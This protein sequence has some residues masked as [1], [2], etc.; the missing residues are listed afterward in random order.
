MALDR[1]NAVEH[2]GTDLGGGTGDNASKGPNGKPQDDEAVPT[3]QEMP[4][5]TVPLN[6]IIAGVV[7][8]AYQDLQNVT[9]M[10]QSKPD[11]E[12]KRV[13][14]TYA[15]SQ[16]QQFIKLLAL[17]RWAKDAGDMKRSMSVHFALDE[18]NTALLSATH[19]LH[20]L[21]REMESLSQPSLDISTAVEVLTTGKFALPRI[22]RR[23]YV[24][25]QP[26]TPKEV[27]ETVRRVEGE[28]RVRL[29][30]DEVVPSVMR[31]NMKID[32][33]CVTFT[34]PNEFSVVLTLDGVGKDAKW[35]VVDIKILVSSVGVGYESVHKG[36]T[37][38]QLHGLK[39]T[40]QNRL[41]GKK[42]G[43]VAVL[44][45]DETKNEPKHYPL[46]ALYDCL[47][48]F[49]LRVQLEVLR[50]QAEHL[51]RTRWKDQLKVEFSGTAGVLRVEFWG[52]GSAGVGPAARPS[53]QT[54]ILEFSIQSEY[55]RSD[56]DWRKVGEEDGGEGE[57]GIDR[58]VSASL[59]YGN[60]G[61]VRRWM[62]GRVLRRGV[63]GEWEEEGVGEG[64]GRVGLDVTGSNLDLEHHL[65]RIVETLAHTLILSIQ[66]TF[67]STA[68]PTSHPTTLKRKRTTSTPTSG[69][70]RFHAD[71]ITVV[72]GLPIPQSSREEGEGGERDTPTP[73][74]SLLVS[75]IP[76]RQ[77]R[78]GISVRTGRVWIREESSSSLSS[79]DESLSRCLAVEGWVNDGR[80]SGVGGVGLGMLSAK[81]GLELEERC[82]EGVRWV[83]GEMM[84]DRVEGMAGEVGLVCLR[85]G[86]VG[87]EEMKKV[88]D[89][90]P[91]HRVFL[92]FRG[93]VDTFIVV[94]VSVCEG[95]GADGGREGRVRWR[96]WVVT[97]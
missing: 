94:G 95:G 56:V 31:R 67:L 97:T 43:N 11:H 82:V 33:G 88:S 77:I 16:R 91:E 65:L 15:L 7:T 20:S 59:T 53:T 52:A 4:E 19:A 40:A 42:K 9:K 44:A 2:P 62:E 10:A 79:N 21:K 6:H 12:K 74:P 37:D 86:V 78:I 73:A 66:S 30:V 22:L 8:T 96:V 63:K 54:R 55:P 48:P 46:V 25:D 72:P 1:G 34:V 47:H 14:M 57:G 27:E 45:E 23:T 36:F 87:D 58:A 76:S 61:S 18:T 38:H 17:T 90:V 70:K 28:M 93:F 83:A 13:L 29:V 64:G 49:C 89:P 71:Q 39:E 35:K 41:W 69:L 84:L 3:L 80:V 32:K 5:N 60:E 24:P 81:I 26:L 51:A 75:I 50:A 68:P 92:R 85:R